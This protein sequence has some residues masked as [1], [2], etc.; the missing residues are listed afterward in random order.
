MTRAPPPTP[1]TLPYLILPPVGTNTQ[2]VS[3][4]ARPLGLPAA[5]QPYVCLA[6]TPLCSLCLHNCTHEAWKIDVLGNTYHFYDSDFPGHLW[7]QIL[8]PLILRIRAKTATPP[9]GGPVTRNSPPSFLLIPGTAS[10]TSTPQAGW[11][12]LAGRSQHEVECICPSCH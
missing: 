7:F 5:R 3:K 10:E 4:A 12:L 11:P 8:C 1:P 6:Y 2:S 9:P